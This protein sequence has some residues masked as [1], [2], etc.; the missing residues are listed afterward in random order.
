M[1]AQSESIAYDER[2][3]VPAVVQDADT[4]QVL[5]LAWMNSEALRLTL[6]TGQ[7]HFWSRSRQELWHKG[8]TSGNVQPVVEIRLDCDADALLLKVN[9]AGPACHTGQ[10]SCFFRPIAEKTETED[11]FEE[12]VSRI[13]DRSV[14]SELFAVI[15]DRRDHPDPGSYTSRLIQQGENEILKKVGEEAIETILA[16]KAQGEQRLVEELADLTYH[17]LVL[18]AS[19]NL[20]PAHIAEELARR[21]RHLS[22][23]T[24][25]R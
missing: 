23:L 6:E 4:G 18:L 10:Q 16:A 20:E 8:A 15:C 24:S 1:N 2:G 17:A 21:R 7:A 14:I 22:T 9:P 25:G 19:R 13:T 5:M 3:L 11:I 12:A